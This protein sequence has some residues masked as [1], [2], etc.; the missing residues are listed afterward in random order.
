[1]TLVDQLEREVDAFFDQQFDPLQ[2]LKDQYKQM[3]KDWE[4][5]NNDEKYITDAFDSLYVSH[6]LD[7]AEWWRNVGREKFHYIF[8]A[9]P[10]IISL[11]ASNAHQERTFSM[12]THF[13]DELRG[14][15]RDD[16]FE[17]SV[18]I[19]VNKGF[20]KIKVPTEEEA[21]V[22]IVETVAQIEG[23]TG[24]EREDALESLGIA[25]IEAAAFQEDAGDLSTPR[26]LSF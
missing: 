3:G 25:N 8:L 23:A 9:V 2:E 19:A 17:Q 22:I 16:K 26:R 12:C 21:A 4:K 18:I 7:L 5:A 15:L 13:N 24:V 10:S 1:L 20:T 6:R 14:R 11:P